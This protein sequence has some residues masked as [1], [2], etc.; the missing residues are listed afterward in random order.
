MTA[1]VVTQAVIAAVL[2][3]LS[4][5][6]V[7]SIARATAR[8][9]LWTGSIR[10]GKTIASLLAWLIFVAHAPRGGELPSRDAAPQIGEN[11]GTAP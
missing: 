6:Q 5:R 2:A 11:P 1:V 3:G 9:N 10:S 4:P 8:V 7:W